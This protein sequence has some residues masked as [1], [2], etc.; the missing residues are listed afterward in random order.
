MTLRVRGYTL[1]VG[2]PCLSRV[3]EGLREG[4]VK[5]GKWGQTRGPVERLGTDRK[6][7]NEVLSSLDPR[8]GGRG[9][10]TISRNSGPG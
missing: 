7:S 1:V 8:T 3:W 4:L 5:N 6:T 10:L 2:S 9:N